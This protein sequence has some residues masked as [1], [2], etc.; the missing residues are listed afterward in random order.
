MA[1]VQRMLPDLKG[2]EANPPKGAPKLLMVSAGTQEANE[3]M[4]SALRWCWIRPSTSGAP[5]AV[6]V[7]AEG[8]IASET[9]IGASRVLELAK[10][11]KARQTT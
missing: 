4:A 8:N 3:A 10:S 7:D 6:L 2:W 5:P 1:S 11:K 9:A